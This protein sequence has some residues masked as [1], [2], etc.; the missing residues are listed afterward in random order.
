MMKVVEAL[1]PPASPA[2]RASTG[3]LAW[4]FLYPW[5]QRPPGLIVYGVL[6]T[7]ASLGVRS[8]M[9]MRK[10]ASTSATRSIPARTCATGLPSKNVYERTGNHP[11]CA[12][13]YDPS[14][15][16]LQQLEVHLAFIDIYAERIRAF[17]V[18][19][20]EFYDLAGKALIRASS[21]GSDRAG[22]FARS[23]TDR[24]TSRRS[25][26]GWLQADLP[27]GGA[28]VGML[29]EERGRTA[30]AKVALY[31]RPT[32]SASPS[33]PSTISPAAPATRRRSGGHWASASAGINRRECV[34]HG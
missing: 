18:K 32:S 16:V 21:P 19:D 30:R 1:L 25:F 6:R 28:G 34:G 33:A 26:R 4:P 3:A 8:S 22:R 5:P 27:L 2:A 23:V 31:P 9:P 29:F 12:I 7:R 15:F 11:R 17:Q 13:N 20:A 10:R 24:S 14:D